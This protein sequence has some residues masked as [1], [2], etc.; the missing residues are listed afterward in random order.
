MRAGKG[1]RPLFPTTTV[2]VLFLVFS[3]FHVF[4]IQV[5]STALPLSSLHFSLRVETHHFYL[6]NSEYQICYVGVNELLLS[7]NQ[8]VERVF[9][10]VQSRKGIEV[11]PLS[12]NT[13]CVC[14]ELCMKCKQNFLYCYNCSYIERVRLYVHMPSGG[15]QLPLVHFPK[16][17][18]LLNSN[19]SI[20]HTFNGRWIQKGLLP[21]NKCAT[22]N[23]TYDFI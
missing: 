23:Q 11:K 19:K 18:L 21:P 9:K 12:V 6:Y 10:G 1:T 5:S 16:K 15:E 8:L 13:S 17:K 7:T 4:R 22:C 3:S 14:M 2:T 20:I